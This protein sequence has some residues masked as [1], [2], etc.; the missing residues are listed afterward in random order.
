MMARGA[1]GGRCTSLREVDF[2]DMSSA[3]FD[4]FRDFFSRLV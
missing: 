1:D 2:Y 4:F 3:A